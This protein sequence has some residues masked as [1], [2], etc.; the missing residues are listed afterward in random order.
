MAQ[1]NQSQIKR[2]MTQWKNTFA[3]YVIK[4]ESPKYR[5]SL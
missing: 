4:A 5:E 2:Q 3:N 1:N